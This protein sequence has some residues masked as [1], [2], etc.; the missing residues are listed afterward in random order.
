MR[1]KTLLPWIVLQ[2]MIT[3]THI[4]ASFSP[5]W[6]ELMILHLSYPTPVSDSQSGERGKLS[7]HE[8]NLGRIWGITT[9]LICVCVSVCQRCLLPKL[10]ADWSTGEKAEIKGNYS[11]S[12]GRERWP[13]RLSKFEGFL[14]ILP[15]KSDPFSSNGAYNHMRT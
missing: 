2:R 10:T 11:I 3:L 12:P 7:W 4:S 8:I 13:R 1:F 5:A 15:W 6:E 9:R 14:F